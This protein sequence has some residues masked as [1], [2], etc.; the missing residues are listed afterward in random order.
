MKLQMLSADGRLSRRKTTCINIPDKPSQMNSFGLK[1]S[2]P[3]YQESK[4]Y[5][6]RSHRLQNGI[7]EWCSSASLTSRTAMGINNPCGTGARTTFDLGLDILTI[8]S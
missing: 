3:L 4:R 2:P 7:G 5:I 8:Q 1:E 6:F